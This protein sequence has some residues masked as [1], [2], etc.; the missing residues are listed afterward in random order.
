MEAVSKSN[1]YESFG[2]YDIQNRAHEY[3]Q[4]SNVH[5]KIS[6]YCKPYHMEHGSLQKVQI[7]F[8]PKSRS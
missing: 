4:Y 3:A 5:C 8:S 2:L 7:D 1:T 6:A